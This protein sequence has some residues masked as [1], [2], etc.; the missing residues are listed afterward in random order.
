MQST[1]WH[2]GMQG[3][4]R[5]L[6]YTITLVSVY[7]VHRLALGHAGGD[8][9]PELVPLPWLVYMQSTGWHLG[10]QGVP[11]ALNWTHYLG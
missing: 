4:T 1:G 7:A 9:G 6:N 8:Q 5:A 2:L 3:M 11:R 10:M